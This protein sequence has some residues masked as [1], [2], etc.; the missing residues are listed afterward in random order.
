[1]KKHLRLLLIL[2]FF[3]GL[4]SAQTEIPARYLFFP[5]ESLKGFDF[6]FCLQ[7]LGA[8]HAIHHLN[9]AE[10]DQFIKT[11]EESFIREKTHLMP[12][13]KGEQLT[14]KNV[15]AAKLT[16]IQSAGCHNLDFETGDYTG[17]A[18]DIG[19]NMNSGMPLTLWG[20][21]ITSLGTD[22]AESSCSYHTL[23]DASSGFDPYGFFPM[24]DPGGGSY[25]VRL[26]GEKINTY[27]TNCSSGY[28]DMGAMQNYSG[29]EI[30][31]QTFL[32][33]PANDLFTYNYAV[34]LQDG[35][36]PTGDQPYFE[37]DVLDG[38][39]TPIPCLQYYMQCTQGVPPAGFQTSFF[40]S[41]VF[42][43]PWQGNSLNLIP[44]L[45]QNVTVVITAAGCNQGG[46]FGY[47]Y[48]DAN[49]GPAVLTTSSPAV[50]AGSTMTIS[51][52]P[53]S[54]GTTFQW[55]EIPSGSGILGSTTG[56]TITIDQSGHY[57]VTVS[58]G[59][60]SY[61]LDTTITFYTY[62]I[63]TA[64]GSNVKCFG[65]ND[66]VVSV[67]ASGTGPFTYS[68]FPAVSTGATA[69]GLG[70][71]T[72]SISVQTAAGCSSSQSVTITQ[73]PPLLAS[74]STVSGTCSQDNG[75]A[76]IIVQGGTGHCTYAWT[77]APAN[78]QTNAI[79]TNLP[80]GIYTCMATD[81]NGCTIQVM[82]TVINAGTPPHPTI[83]ASGTTAL[84]SPDSVVLTA[85]GAS[86]YSWSTGSTASSITVHNAGVYIVY[87]TSTCG[88]DSAKQPVTLSQKP[89]LVLTGGGTICQG[90]IATLNATGGGTYLWSTGSNQNSIAV[91]T[92]GIYTVISSNICGSD[93]A[94]A[95]VDVSTVQAS[96]TPSVSSGLPP[97]NVIF[98]DASSLNVNSWDWSFGNGDTA[99]SKN[100]SFTFHNPGTYTVL[101]SV[102]NAIGCK[103]TH[104]TVI[105]VNE[106][107]SWIVTPNVFTPN[108]DGNNDFFYFDSKG[109]SNFHATIFDR[110]GVI[111]SELL[112]PEQGWDGRTIAGEPASD[113]TYYY[114]VHATGDD[115]KVYDLKGFVMLM[116]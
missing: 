10:K 26:G 1:M 80:P 76:G 50:C 25:A 114:L 22:A 23:V 52:P 39:G 14:Y 85:T 103:A 38:T 109:I 65:R 78:M 100:S 63:L 58:Y 60:C 67:S 99:A 69:S 106:I 20:S 5:A 46:H 105:V 61:S 62:P 86:T 29:G 27:N 108:G 16:K 84:C 17:W 33:T 102:T 81:S 11:H 82:D 2:T 51:A 90:D 64:S 41:G 57:E 97:L 19:Y 21:G 42:Y 66:G 6:H 7:E 9:D 87:A 15:P 68:W 35:G 110:W 40:N 3:S 91:T 75:S 36:H 34:V 31:K 98:T 30:L 12:A 74:G 43:C 83:S 107:P 56:P 88:T 54:P 111:L 94:S 18:G 37:V 93:T 8:Y 28:A 4:L 47:A 73:P 13:S 96:F 115:G 44:Y 48:V 101:L 112:A 45:G 92:S 32:V 113:G 71:G 24:L 59:A 104:E 70:P 72:Y 77:P 49:C 79:V 95:T 116:R 53:S 89:N 55:I